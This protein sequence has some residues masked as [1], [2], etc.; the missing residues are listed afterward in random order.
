MK[1]NFDATNIEELLQFFRKHLLENDKS[2]GTCETYCINVRLFAEY[3]TETFA[4]NFDP[5]KIS[6]L[7]VREYRNYLLNV[8]NLSVNTVN[9]RISTLNEFYKY[10]TNENIVSTNPVEKIRKIRMQSPP[11]R[12][13]IDDLMFKR[14]RRQFEHYGREVEKVIFFLLFLTGVRV[15][16][17]INIKVDDI[18]INPRSGILKVQS[19]KGMKYREIPLN[20]TCRQVISDYIEYRKSKGINS[21]YLI[22]T[23]RS[24]K[25]CRSSI[26]KILKKH[27]NKIGFPEISPHVA[28]RYFL[29][30][31]LEVSDISTAMELAG[32][33]SV[34]TTIQYVP[35][36]EKRKQDAVTKITN[37]ID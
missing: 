11:K 1:D 34:Q 22:T 12:V 17:L 36:T 18:V 35:S 25:A 7:D 14:L 20:A 28:R 23:E 4:E 15:S 6:P 29:T 37:D 10:L 30:K 24:T 2:A 32:H 31:V 19:G 33:S 3:I 8:K 21:P 27:G 16:E 9:N 13:T 26:N 5:R